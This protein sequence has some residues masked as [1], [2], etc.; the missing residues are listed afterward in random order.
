MKRVGRI[1]AAERATQPV[2]TLEPQ[3]SQP[4]ASLSPA[5][6]EVFQL[7]VNDCSEDHFRES[8]WPILEQFCEASALASLAIKNLQADPTNAKWLAVWIQST[9]VLGS[10][11]LRLRISP[12]ARRER[13]V[14][15]KP[16]D[17]S[18]QFRQSQVR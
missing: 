14:A 8:D 9:K 10:L 5:A 1:S 3:P 7:I 2:T 11:S 12:Q 17:W 15:Q 6:Q 4:P 13:A 16:L 18:A